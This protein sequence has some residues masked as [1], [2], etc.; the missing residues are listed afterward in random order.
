MASSEY[1]LEDLL[2]HDAWI[3]ALAQQL[4]A[5]EHA[6]ED[7]AQDAWIV[8]LGGPAPEHGRTGAWFHGLVRN[9]AFT[10]T[11]SLRRRRKREE[12][13]AQPE[14]LPSVEELYE[15]EK[16][17][18]KVATAVF[19]LE[20]PYRSAIFHRFYENQPPREI[21]ARLNVSVA[22]V[23][24]R[25]RRGLQQLRARLDRDF[26]DRKTWCTALLPLTV[27]PAAKAAA[28]TA[29]SAITGALVMSMKMKIGIAVIVALGAAYA[30]WP[31]NEVKP[32]EVPRTGVSQSAP[33]AVTEAPTDQAG[34]TGQ[35]RAPAPVAA[36]Q[37]PAGVRRDG[38]TVTGTVR[39]T[40]G[41]PIARA[42]VRL[43]QRRAA[44]LDP[45]KEMLDVSCETDANGCF[46]FRGIRLEYYLWVH[47]VAEAPGFY[48]DH[49]QVELGG[50]VDFNLGRPGVLSGRVTLV[51]DG[52][53]CAGITVAVEGIR[54]DPERS[55]T[56][57]YGHYRI[58]G[59]KPG[60]RRVSA[61][62]ADYP[63]L[64]GI[65]VVV[66][67]GRETVADIAL[68][69]GFTLCGRVI[70]EVTQVPIHGAR[71]R[72]Y[73]YSPD[74]KWVETDPQGNFRMTGLR[75]R[76][77]VMIFADRYATLK[78]NFLR[79]AG[80]NEN[81]REF[82][83]ARAAAIE[84]RVIG[85]AGQPV[86]GAAVRAT[87]RGRDLLDR[88]V[89][90]E[91]GRFHLKSVP[92]GVE[93]RLL[94][95]KD[96]LARAVSDPLTL[97][98]DETRAGLE[99]RLGRG[100][101]ISGRLSDSAGTPITRGTVELKPGS[102]AYTQ[103]HSDHSDHEGIY[104]ITAAPAGC[105]RLEVRAPGLVGTMRRDLVVEEGVDHTS[106][107]FQLDRGRTTTG[108]VEDPGGHPIQ[109]ATVHAHPLGTGKD[110]MYVGQQAE[111]DAH[112]RFTLTGLVSSAY[113][114]VPVREG[115]RRLGR[116]VRVQAGA[117]NVAVTMA[118][119]LDIVGHVLHA[120]TGA[121]VTEFIVRR[122]SGPASGHRFSDHKGRF[123][124]TR[125]S[126]GV[127]YLEARTPD[128]LASDTPVEVRL[129]HGSN[130]GP[131]VLRVGPSAALAGRILDPDGRPVEGAWIKAF[132]ASG[133]LANRVARAGSDREGNFE[134]VP[135]PPGEYRLHV[136]HRDWIEVE[137]R[138][139]IRREKENR[140]EVTLL[141]EGGTFEI[142]VRDPAGRPIEGAF[143]RLKRIN[144]QGLAPDRFKTERFLREKHKDLPDEDVKKLIRRYYSSN[145]RGIIERRFIPPGRYSIEVGKKGYRKGR[146][147]AEAQ[148]GVRTHL[149]VTLKAE[150]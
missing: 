116:G 99:L 123:Q 23:E 35:A 145:A 114:L 81:V 119:Y 86:A 22:A 103:L 58:E 97:R 75:D 113:R 27:P 43:L 92:A 17:R 64:R 141:E 115:Y 10:R 100:S 107:D 50:H 63:P 73:D 108:R 29:T 24:S 68:G 149:S 74:L 42:R 135:I 93:V 21:A 16:T 4:V 53:R 78:A 142:T 71:V 13:A 132:R 144:G 46:S 102:W 3:R 48:R 18:Y 7:I 85:P 40:A 45:S 41:L 83:L 44:V 14:K 80:E 122:N 147:E 61:T 47:V 67:P 138:T 104:R 88:T 126:P 26:G 139:V 52:T 120:A 110:R 91:D 137:Q 39:D 90:R 51:G 70:D 136:S 69:M 8:A 57:P 34:A 121:P 131:V 124:L 9:L 125:L 77:P 72:A 82:R 66:E 105:F 20:E 56:D 59:L 150:K 96:G 62:S 95:R 60:R 11:R 38:A 33:P 89:S 109:G 117:Q 148:A 30:I 133:E 111:T 12:R 32:P 140:V 5:D 1:I 55:I 143:H 25:L 118:P 54:L 112:G 84:G 6:A 134:I 127:H 49:K 129:A 106:I 37:E 87:R 76:T 2:A 36:A 146:A 130:L 128:G 31:G 94:A 19:A 98:M 65:S 28:A 101:T 15:H 79:P